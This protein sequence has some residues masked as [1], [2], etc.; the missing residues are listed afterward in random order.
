MPK[1]K[2]LLLGSY[3]QTNLGDDLLMWNYLTWL[4]ERGFEHIITNVDKAERV[5]A[6][7]RQSY[8]DVH[9]LET[10]RTGIIAWLR[11]LRQVDCVVYG[12][13]TI[14]KEL[15]GS[16]GRF[17]H[18]VTL[19]MMVL[20]CLA[21]L[22]GA[23]VYHLHIGIGSIKTR[24]GRLIARL[25]LRA[26]TYT[27]FRDQQSYEY[28]RG[29]LGLPPKRI[30]QS[31]D[32][33]FID[34]RWK[35]VW[36]EAPAMPHKKRGKVIGINLLSDIPD[37]VNRQHYLATARKLIRRL[38]QAGHS[39]VLVPFQHAAS[40]SNDLA[41]IQKEIVPHIQGQDG[42]QLLKSVQ[43]DEIGSLM[44][45]CDVFIGMRFH[46]LLL[47]TVTHT[48][49][50]AI[51][52][53]TKCERFVSEIDYPHAVKLEDLTLAAVETACNDALRETRQIKHMLGRVRAAQY[54]EAGE[55]L[56]NFT[57]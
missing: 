14:Y 15:Y 9:M 38:C 22:M 56:R 35:N 7:I 6:I 19:R 8:P 20:N 52:Y 32:G 29:T 13:G 43:I 34:Q 28:A 24:T 42:W 51:M 50:V 49:F 23:K 57:F 16:T 21:R 27:I 44:S 17:K 41:F 48:P 55:C 18:A 47:A 30:C 53:D 39:V 45:Q 10:Y 33:L 46:S 1:K 12:G 31:T 26:A 5:P 4:K 25:G 37:W 36:H 3:G 2:V 40:P 54:K 11:V